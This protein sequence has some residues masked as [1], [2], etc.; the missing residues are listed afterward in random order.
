VKVLHAAFRHDPRDPDASSG[1]DY[2]F[3]TA[4]RREGLDVRI[5]GPFPD[6]F[7]WYE[8]AARRVYQRVTG[9]RYLKWDVTS[10]W[11]ASQTVN[12]M[13][14]S[15][16]PD[17]VFSIFPAPLV[18]YEGNAPC[19]FNTDITFQ[20]MHEGG[21]PM[22]RLAL[23][24][25][26]WLEGRA[27]R[28]CASVLA[29]SAWCKREILRMHPKD[30]AA[31]KVLPMPSALPLSVVPGQV[32][33]EQAKHLPAEGEPLRLL[34]VGRDFHRKGVDLAVEMVRL[35][36]ARG[37]PAELTVCATEGPPREHVRYVGPFRKSVPEELARYAA[38][39]REAHLLLHPARFEA[40]GIV[41]GEA[42]AF[43]TPTLTND[44][45]GLGTTVADGES[46]VVLPRWSPPRAYVAAI[47]ALVGSPARYYALCRSARARYERELNWEATGRRIVRLLRELAGRSKRA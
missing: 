32:D 38:L 39:Y 5:A 41:P 36:N 7:P 35:L 8:H 40:A 3:Y 26:N 4:M 45:Q 1:V 25:S 42:A 30:P 9:G 28:R 18:W 27:I 14:A 12:R 2:N 34:L 13:E 23:R 29:F 22:G 21:R 15:W 11:K 17:V 20:A 6:S 10:I 47:E 24:M 31:I 46:G 43:A 19:V 33:V 37:T 44:V 16:Q